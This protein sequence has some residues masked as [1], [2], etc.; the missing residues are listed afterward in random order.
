[1]GVN[2][3]VNEFYKLCYVDLPWLYFTD[4]MDNQW[5]DDWDDAPYEHNAGAP[6]DRDTNVLKVAFDLGTTWLLTPFENCKKHKG[7]SISVQEIN[8]SNLPWLRSWTGDPQDNLLPGTSINE[9]FEFIHRLGGEIYTKTIHNE[10]ITDERKKQ[11]MD[12]VKAGGMVVCKNE[13]ESDYI[14]RMVHQSARRSSVMRW[15][16]IKDYE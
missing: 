12:Q 4:N 13:Y 11:L 14:N 8:D 9:V 1:M 16:D 7:R 10:L 15:E 5:G 2:K 3:I 6:Y